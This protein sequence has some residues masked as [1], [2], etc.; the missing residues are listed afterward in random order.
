MSHFAG[1]SKALK[2]RATACVMRSAVKD[3]GIGIDRI[4]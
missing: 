3:S 4:G 1:T 2:N